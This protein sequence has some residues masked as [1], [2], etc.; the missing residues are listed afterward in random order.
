VPF[1]RATILGLF[2]IFMVGNGYGQKIDPKAKPLKI[3]GSLGGSFNYYNMQGVTQRRLPYG[4][5]LFGSVN[6]SIYGWSLP[7]SVAISQQ[8]TAFS[9]PFARYGVSPEYKWVKLYLGYRNMRF[10]EFTMNGITFLGAGVELTPG[11]FRF[12]AM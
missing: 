2:V 9:H 11:K 12:S 5:S 1:L 8:G 7:F 10:S 4:Y 3:R 6:L